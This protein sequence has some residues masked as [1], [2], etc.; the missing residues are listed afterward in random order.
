MAV[1]KMRAPDNVVHAIPLLGDT[2][3]WTPPHGDYKPHEYVRVDDDT[4]TTCLTC[5]RHRQGRDAS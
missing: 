5:I 2:H 4:P 3:L 1:H